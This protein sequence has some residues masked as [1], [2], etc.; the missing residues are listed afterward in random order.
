MGSLVWFWSIKSKTHTVSLVLLV[1]HHCGVW[2]LCL[3]SITGHVY[4]LLLFCK[5]KP[6][7][8]VQCF[9]IRELVTVSI[10][11]YLLNNSVLILS[12]GGWTPQNGRSIWFMNTWQQWGIQTQCGYNKKQPTQTSAVW[13]A[14]T[15]VSTGAQWQ[16]FLIHAH[17]SL[18]SI[19]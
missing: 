6:L 13:S 7:L 19:S 10:K 17:C 16:S 9:K 18:Y 15:V 2:L 5:C 3:Q 4:S 8:M 14:F 11:L 12:L 1:P